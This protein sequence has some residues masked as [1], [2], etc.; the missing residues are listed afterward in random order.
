MI[1]NGLHLRGTQVEPSAKAEAVL[2]RWPDSF[3]IDRHSVLPAGTLSE[4]EVVCRRQ[5]PISLVVHDEGE[6]LRMIIAVVGDDVE[7]HPSKHLHH[8]SVVACE[9]GRDLE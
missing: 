5:P 2:S 8:V 4:A 6:V 7:D 1:H 3:A 9:G